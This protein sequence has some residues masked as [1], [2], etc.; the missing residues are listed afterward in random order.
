MTVR[1]ERTNS[2]NKD[3]RYL[4]RLLDFLFGIGFAYVGLES[5]LCLERSDK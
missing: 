4:I 2:N 5:R 3:F 1:I